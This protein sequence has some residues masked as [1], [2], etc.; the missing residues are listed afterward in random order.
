MKYIIALLFINHYKNIGFKDLWV[1]LTGQ[2]TPPNNPSEPLVVR[3]AKRLSKKQDLKYIDYF[4]WLDV[5]KGLACY[6]INDMTAFQELLKESVCSTAHEYLN[7]E[8]R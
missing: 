5:G 2:E 8:G 7:T 6:S 1:V 4:I 3:Y